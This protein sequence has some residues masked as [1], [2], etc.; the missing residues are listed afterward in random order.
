M[1]CSSPNL[2]NWLLKPLQH[3]KST[4]LQLLWQH[5]HP[6]G[7]KNANAAPEHC[8]KKKSWLLDFLPLLQLWCWH[9]Q[10]AVILWAIWNAWCAWASKLLLCLSSQAL[11][12]NNFHEW[13][14]DR[15]SLLASKRCLDSDS[16]SMSQTVSGTHKAG[17]SCWKHSRYS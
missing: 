3:D 8:T 6:S 17:R 1:M 15:H 9:P 4:I 13:D 11:W 2:T 10:S 5:L 16:L 12:S 7:G 14:N